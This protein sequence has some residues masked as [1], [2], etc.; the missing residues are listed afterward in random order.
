MAKKNTFAG[1]GKTAAKLQ[2]KKQIKTQAAAE[3][4]QPMLRAMVWYKEEDYETLLALF[5]DAEL[6]PPTHAEWLVRADE[7]KS[8][9]EEAGDQ[10]IKVFIDPETFPRWCESR[11]LPKDANSRSQLA[12]EVAQVNSFSV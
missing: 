1:S 9:V 4:H 6:L 7:K 2:E 8:E 10:V 3:N 11:K 12:L 5:D